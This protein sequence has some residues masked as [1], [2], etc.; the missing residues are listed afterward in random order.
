MDPRKVLLLLVS[1]IVCVALCFSLF[2]L[3]ENLDA[4]Q[5]MVIQSPVS[6]TLNW[7]T[8]P[9]VKWQ[10][11]GKVTKY[12]KRAQLWF[13]AKQDQGSTADESLKIRFNDGGHANISG[14]LSWEMP[15]DE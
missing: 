4:G 12:N 11:F 6:G 3:F 7:H 2:G 8:T 13:S 14:G 10:G 1:V 15:L 9:G 5:V